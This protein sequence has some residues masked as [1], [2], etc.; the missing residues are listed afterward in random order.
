VLFEA[1]VV[2]VVASESAE[3]A[4]FLRRWAVGFI[5]ILV[6]RICSDVIQKR[7]RFTHVKLIKIVVQ[8]DLTYQAEV[9]RSLKIR[10]YFTLL[11]HVPS[12]SFSPAVFEASL[13]LRGSSCR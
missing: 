1:V 2:P 13:I 3:A 10:Q 7:I 4:C 5:D 8:C 11:K 12:Y 6:I 9:V